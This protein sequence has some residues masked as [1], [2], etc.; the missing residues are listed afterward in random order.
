MTASEDI[1]LSSPSVLKVPVGGLWSTRRNRRRHHADKHMSVYE[2]ALSPLISR[3]PPQHH[4]PSS[5]SP[6][7]NPLALSPSHPLN[8]DPSCH[9]LCL[10]LMINSLSHCPTLSHHP[11]ILSS[12]LITSFLTVPTTFNVTS[13]WPFQ[14]RYIFIMTPHGCCDRRGGP[15]RGSYKG[16]WGVTWVDE[17]PRMRMVI[18]T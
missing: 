4:S 11:T 12:P 3:S 10:P 2:R 18:K 1:Y 8:Y 17:G 6:T 5:P 15:N 16:W 13:A 14:T 7:S 9:P